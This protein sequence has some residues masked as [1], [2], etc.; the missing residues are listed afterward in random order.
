MDRFEGPMFQSSEW[1]PGV[2]VAGKRVAV[3]STGDVDADRPRLRRGRLP[4]DGE[5]HEADVVVL[6]TGLNAS[7]MLWPMDIRGRTGKTLREQW[8]DDDASAYLG[9][10]VP[11]FRTSSS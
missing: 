6:A 3:V 5:A 8:G 1:D 4:A 7:R 9:I 11:D 10:A 2:D